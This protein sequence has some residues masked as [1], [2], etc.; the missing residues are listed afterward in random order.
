MNR[1][2]RKSCRMTTPP[3]LGRTKISANVPCGHSESAPKERSNTAAAVYCE[4]RM[5]GPS[6]YSDEV[7]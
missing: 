1:T 3:A 5:A 6:R 4:M 2:G 7:P